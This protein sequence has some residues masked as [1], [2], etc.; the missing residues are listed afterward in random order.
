MKFSATITGW[1]EDAL[2]FLAEK[3]LNFVIIFNDNAPEELKEISILHTPSQV[4]VEPTP[5]DTLMFCGKAFDIT[6]VGEEAKYTL[7]TLGHCT[8]SFQ[9]GTEP[10]RPGCIML[11]GTDPL[12]PEDVK[13]GGKIE[14][15]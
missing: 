3:D 2:G 6:A 13:T 15:F 14:I 8:L 7:R 9:G 5:G 11:E 12:T 1:G 10:E 4:F